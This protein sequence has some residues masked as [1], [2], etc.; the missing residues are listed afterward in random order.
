VTD[1]GEAG[2]VERVKRVLDLSFAQCVEMCYPYSKRRVEGGETI[3][4]HH[5][6]THVYCY[7]M[8]LRVPEGFSSTTLILLKELIHEYMVSSALADWLGITNPEAAANWRAK[9]ADIA[10]EIEKVKN[11]RG[12]AF[13]RRTNPW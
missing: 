1:I 13:T 4:D 5:L 7:V 6:N 2:N 12:R 10:S 11:H 8:E 3:D 9:L